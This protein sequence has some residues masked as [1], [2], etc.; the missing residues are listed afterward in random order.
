M[1]SR[2]AL[3]LAVFSL[4]P[5]L[6]LA[7][8]FKAGE[9]VVVIHDSAPIR[10]EN[11]IVDRARVGSIFSLRRIDGSKLWI[12][13]QKPGWIDQADVLSLQRAWAYFST[14]LEDDPRDETARRA[15]IN[16]LSAQGLFDAAI[17]DLTDLL[18]QAPTDD[19]LWNARGQM[20]ILKGDHA[21][22]ILDFSEAIRRSPR[23]I[24]F[25]HRGDA[26][27]RNGDYAKAAFDWKAA[28]A[29]RPD[30]PEAHRSLAR[31]YSRVPVEHFRNGPEGVKHSMAACELSKWQNPH[32]LAL[33]AASH[34]QAGQFDEAVDWQNKANALFE[35]RSERLHGELCRD[36]FKCREIEPV[37]DPQRKSYKPSDRIV[38]IRDAA[39]VADRKA[40]ERVSMGWV[41]TVQAVDGSKLL[42]DAKAPGWIER[43]YV[44]P[45]DEGIAYF[46][47][48]I[49]RLPTFVGALRARGLMY[50]AD[51][52]ADQAIED[53]SEVIRLDPN[54]SF[55]WNDRGRAWLAS[56]NY[57][58]A[59]ADHTEEIRLNPENDEAYC[60]RARAWEK[61]GDSDE[62]IADCGEAI[63]LNPANA[64][65]F[66]IRGF[67]WAK[68]RK[69]DRAIDD[70]T[71]CIETDPHF[72]LAYLNRG[73]AYAARKEFDSAIRD[74]TQ[75]GQLEPNN[76]WAHYNRG[77]AWKAK[78][79]FQKAIHDYEEAM[80]IKPDDALC[81]NQLAWVLATCS[82]DSVRDGARAV[83]LATRACELSQW[84]DAGKLDTLAVA[85]AEAG[86]F[87]EAVK[88]QQKSLDAGPKNPLSLGPRKR[89]ELYKQGKPYRE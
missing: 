82:D 57:D 71:H 54:N 24:Y 19:A 41:Y 36:L 11:R 58:K 48:L 87:E 62:V 67:M 3:M 85:Y 47:Q 8:P 44:I 25:N 64:W 16:V 4:A 75:Y 61:K 81:L 55:A 23:S 12:N 15:R 2:L 88:W 14:L 13:S 34:A 77:N 78:R 66:N 65:A 10:I 32:D 9:R 39:I 26:E 84:K 80:R 76:F 49:E 53:F 29:L 22:A 27:V 40:I 72:A 73:N 56:G 43:R 17:A 51:Q 31:L 86:K 28:L 42:V 83:E 70:Y 63:R 6:A 20:L 89:L 52:K 38:V 5:A 18:R 33:L 1:S 59:I 50:L 30:L 46:S 7:D 37:D 45:F 69:T 79:E 21:A 74:F 68:K 60:H 35:A